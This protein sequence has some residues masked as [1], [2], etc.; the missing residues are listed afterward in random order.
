MTSFDDCGHEILLYKYKANREEA[1]RALG[2]DCYNDF[3]LSLQ[4]SLENPEE[5]SIQLDDSYTD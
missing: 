5:I 4:I 1:A 2:F 3:I